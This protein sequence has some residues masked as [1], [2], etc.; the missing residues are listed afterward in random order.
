MP[1]PLHILADRKNDEMIPARY[2]CDGNNEF[3]ILTITNVD[4]ESKSLALIVDDPDAPVGTRDHY[5]L[6]NIPNTGVQLQISG[7]TE[8][9]AIP[10]KNSR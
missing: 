5:L 9:N 3:P 8:K 10:G 1:A 6:A 2:T 7:D 4:A